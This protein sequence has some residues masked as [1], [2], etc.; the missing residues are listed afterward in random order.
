MNK[1][2]TV[3]VQQVDEQ[4]IEIPPEL[5]EQLDW[6]E[7]DDIKFDIQ[8]DGSIHLKKVEL[9]AVELDF[10]DDD[11]LK[12]MIAAHSSGLTF[13]EFCHQALEEHLTKEEFNSE[14]G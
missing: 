14:C 5:L 11:L 6:K 2:Y 9:E 7:G 13:N 1:K 3:E 12:I 4:F 10:D 8:K